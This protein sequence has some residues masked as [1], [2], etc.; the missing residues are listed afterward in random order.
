MDILQEVELL[1]AVRIITAADS[2]GNDL[3]TDLRFHEDRRSQ[4]GN[5]SL[6][7]D[8]V[9]ITRSHCGRIQSQALSG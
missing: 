8:T 1:P 4:I 2:D 9:M 5:G 6:K 3:L 7:A